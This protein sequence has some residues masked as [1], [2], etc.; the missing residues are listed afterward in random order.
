MV[1]HYTRGIEILIVCTGNTCR[2]PMAEALLRHSLDTRAIPATVSSA[3]LLFDGEPATGTA[4]DT[5]D[6]LGLDL[7]RHR[8]RVITPDLV[9]SA[10]LVVAMAREHVR[11]VVIRRPDRYGRVFTLRELVRRGDEA[12]SRP[13]DESIEAWLARLHVGRRP[14]SHQGSSSL[15]DIADPVGRGPGVYAR[16]AAD[17]G[18]LVTRLTDLLWDPAHAIAGTPLG[19]SALPDR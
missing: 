17:L 10:D 14:S 7:H 13:A 1:A 16:T 2:S 5:L 3:G 4:V 11:E 18:V 6:E 15:D 19:R 8:S 9:G 12:G